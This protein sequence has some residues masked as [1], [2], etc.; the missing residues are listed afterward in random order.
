MMFIS[1]VIC[2]YNAVKFIVNFETKY[3]TSLEQYK[4]NTSMN[5]EFLKD[6]LMDK[7]VMTI[8][9]EPLINILQ[10]LKSFHQDYSFT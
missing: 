6:I 4:K 3:A 1:V 9:K 2:S 5:I 10:F 8:Y 7:I